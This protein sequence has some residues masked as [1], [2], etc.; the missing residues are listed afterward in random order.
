M[1][2]IKPFKFIFKKLTPQEFA[3]VFEREAF[4]T[5]AFILSFAPGSEYVKAVLD[6]YKDDKFTALVAKYLATVE[7]TEVDLSFV[8]RVE[9]HLK[10]ILTNSNRAISKELRKNLVL[11]KNE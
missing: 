11:E 4:Q 2:K 3:N 5:R 10:D 1:T 8:S 7:K 6:I 9:N